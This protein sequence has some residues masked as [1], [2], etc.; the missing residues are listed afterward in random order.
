MHNLPDLAENIIL[1]TLRSIRMHINQRIDV[2][3]AVMND[4][5]LYNV[6]SML[7]QRPLKNKGH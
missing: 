7:S 1:P 2:K 4:N 3:L 6:M 5:N